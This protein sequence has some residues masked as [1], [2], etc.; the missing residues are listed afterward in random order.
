LSALPSLG[1]LSGSPKSGG[2]LVETLAATLRIAPA[3]IQATSLNVVA[4]AIGTL[5][6]SGTIS[7]MG[8]LNFAMRATL[9]GSSVIG[10]VSRVISLPESGNGIPFRIMGTMANPIFVPDVGRAVGDFIASPDAAA[11]AAGVLGGLFGRSKR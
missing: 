10:E 5:T 1:G 6:G 8:D 7:A 2:T 3:G 4:P 9:S 11:K